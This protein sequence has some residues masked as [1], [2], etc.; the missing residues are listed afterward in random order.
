MFLKALQGLINTP[1]TFKWSGIV[2]T[3]E[4]ERKQVFRDDQKTLNFE[5]VSIFQMT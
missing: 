2:F 4:G 3:P 5:K 1:Q